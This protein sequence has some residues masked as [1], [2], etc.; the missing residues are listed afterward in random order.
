M[1]L[2]DDKTTVTAVIS[3]ELKQKLKTIAKARR[4]SL[5]QATGALIE[6]C[7]EDWMKGL[8]IEPDKGSG[9]KTK[10]KT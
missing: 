10:S 6:D 3:N 7:L 8:G 5:S 2:G 4:W 1:P 9:N